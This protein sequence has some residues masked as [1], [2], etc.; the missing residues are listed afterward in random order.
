MIYT[1]ENMQHEGERIKKEIE[2][3]QRQLET[4]VSSDR[5]RDIQAAINH[6]KQKEQAW[7]RPH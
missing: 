1:E 5:R 4:P 6:L 3:L 7:R 2:R